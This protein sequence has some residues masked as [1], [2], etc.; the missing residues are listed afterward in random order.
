MRTMHLPVADALGQRTAM[1]RAPGAAADAYLPAHKPN[2]LPQPRHLELPTTA[3]TVAAE[4]SC[5]ASSVGSTRSPSRPLTPSS[6]PALQ[7][8]PAVPAN[9]GALG[10]STSMPRMAP[11]R[12][13]QASTPDA[14]HGRPV[15]R[16][17]FEL[18]PLAREDERPTTTGQQVRLKGAL[19]ALQGGAGAAGPGGGSGSGGGNKDDD[20]ISPY[21]EAQR[22]RREI[23][24]LRAACEQ[25]LSSAE[26]DKRAALE[27][28]R[29]ELTGSQ[30]EVMALRRHEE[31]LER[32]ELMRR[33]VLRR[34]MHTA[35]H[36]GFAAWFELWHA[37][38]LAVTRL[39][40]VRARLHHHSG[41]APAFTLWRDTWSG[42]RA[43]AHTEAQEERIASLEAAL[44]AADSARRAALEAQRV[45]LAGGAEEKLQL[46]LNK[47]RDARVELLVRQTLRR[48]R[49]FALTTGW[50]SWMALWEARTSALLRLRQ[51]SSRL[52]VPELEL[53]FNFWADWSEAAQRAA[54][55][56]RLERER[57]SLEAQLRDARF[58]IGQLS[59]L[60]AAHAE[61]VRTLNEKLSTLTGELRTKEGL[62]AEAQRFREENDSLRDLHAFSEEAASA[63][64]QRRADVEASVAKQLSENQELLE[65]LLGQ[66][67]RKFEEEVIQQR[68]HTHA[69]RA[70][71]LSHPPRLCDPPPPHLRTVPMHCPPRY[72]H[73]APHGA[74]I[75]APA[76]TC[77]PRIQ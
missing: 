9:T 77:V 50:N 29:V 25:R 47:E 55:A 71:A 7:Y 73:T 10:T 3:A 6:L 5:G 67:R 36:H 20:R 40:F 15:P 53:A 33:Q 30:G 75:N 28:L 61:E 27:A 2:T 37:R 35:M 12:A 16:T 18:H 44:A 8:T 76:H 64:E 68:A 52:R 45:E 51:A 58:E 1:S 43:R 21:D 42:E 72:P 4:P 74:C 17:A 46:R 59:M 48:M 65:R 13:Q 57:G 31:R 49:H 39:T 62:M 69:H 70:S 63:A 26:D 14:R 32:I 19:P 60:R 11:S 56:A 24:K 23:K 66:Q 41:L 54:E 38:R 34:M 22:L